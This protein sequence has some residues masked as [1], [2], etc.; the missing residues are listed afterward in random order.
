ME[1]QTRDYL[2]SSYV[3]CICTCI[4]VHFPYKSYCYF[5]RTATRNILSIQASLCD[6]MSLQSP[7]HF[8][9][10]N[11]CC[12][13]GRSNFLMGNCKWVV[14]DIYMYLLFYAVSPLRS[15]TIIYYVLQRKCKEREIRKRSKSI[16]PRWLT[17]IALFADSHV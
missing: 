8:H 10:V 16:L 5:L 7:N 6:E 15:L 2:V 9:L 12:Q 1:L 17:M 4:L 14:T 13:R 3:F 11:S